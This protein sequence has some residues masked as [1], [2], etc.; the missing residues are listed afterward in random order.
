[1]YIIHFTN[2]TQGEL[3]CITERSLTKINN[4]KRREIEHFK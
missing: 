2:T 4:L 1:M 3:Y